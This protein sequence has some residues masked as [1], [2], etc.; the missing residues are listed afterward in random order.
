MNEFELIKLLTQDAPRS[1]GDLIQGVGDDCAVIDVKDKRWLITTDTLF[2]GVHFKLAYI[3]PRSLGRRVLNINFSDIAAMGGT[4]NFYI[5]SLAI[6]GGFD[7][8]RCVELYRGM[9]DAAAPYQA[10]LIGG[11]TVRSPEN[12]TLTITVMGRIEGIQPI[13]RSGAKAGDAIYVTGTMGDAAL[14]LKCLTRNQITSE[15]SYF[16]ERYRNPVARVNT[17]NR[18]AKSGLVTSMI[19]ISD[20][21][22]AD[23]GHLADSSK[24]GYEISLSRIPAHEGFFSICSKLGEHAEELNLA[25]GDDYELAFTVSGDGVEEFERMIRS[26]EKPFGH[27]I[28]RIG[29]MITDSKRQ[30]VLN[31]DDEVVPILHKGYDHLEAFK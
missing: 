13:L 1:L 16:I 24:T 21:L 20:G 26:R 6:P 30:V 29:T 18:L 31:Q 5:V 19:D 4:P 3:D 7:H 15:T 28:T 9:S 23:I 27:K 17:G 14:G 2:E 10:T 11:D 8:L 25:G 22:I 12:L